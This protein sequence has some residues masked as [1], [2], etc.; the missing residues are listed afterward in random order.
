MTE[1]PRAKVLD[2]LDH[3]LTELLALTEGPDLRE[4]HRRLAVASDEVR[5]LHSPSDPPMVPDL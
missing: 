5:R 2:R 3:K 4:L 1:S